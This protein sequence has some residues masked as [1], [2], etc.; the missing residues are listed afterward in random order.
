MNA[1]ELPSDSEKVLL[2]VLISAGRHLVGYLRL[3]M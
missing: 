1:S 3:F 2:I